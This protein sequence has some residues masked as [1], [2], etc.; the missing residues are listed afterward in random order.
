MEIVLVFATHCQ[1]RPN[2]ISSLNPQC[3][4]ASASAVPILR[5]GQDQG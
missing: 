1:V 2:S 5:R 3:V 4:P